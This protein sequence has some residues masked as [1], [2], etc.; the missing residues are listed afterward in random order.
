[1][2]WP[3]VPAGS[4]GPHAT[5]KL[6][7]MAA[8]GPEGIE[9]TTDR[10]M[11]A[12]YVEALG[13]AEAI[14]VGALPIPKPG[15]SDVLVEVA[16][17]AANPVDTLVRS[18]R[19]ATPVSF[20]FVV[21]RDL[22]GR[23]V[24]A[25]PGAGFSPGETVWCNSLGHDGRQGSFSSY[26]VV[27]AERAY[28]LPPGVEPATAVG[29]AHPAATAYLGLFVHG[30]ISPAAAVYIGGGAGNVGSAAIAMAVRAGARVVCSARPDDSPACRAAGA[31]VVLDYRADLTTRLKEAMPNGADIF[32]DTSGHHDFDL[33]AEVAATGA[34]VVLSAVSG[35]DEPALPVRRL[36][37]RDLALVGFVISRASV[38]ELAAAAELIND[39]LVRDQLPVRITETVPLSATAEVHRRLETG[40]VRGRVLLR[41]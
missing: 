7:A 12:A 24:Q 19:Y 37:T 29:V 31:E 40:T 16:L 36:Y 28:R 3:D 35:R 5:D 41:P 34:R 2:E 17:V 1:M 25:G 23:V 38:A 30:R 39:M 13:P 9:G 11:T 21:G 4:G 8:A 15:P 18:G 6:G 10:A 32:W 20:P 14:R 33:A 22:V 26:A 27:P